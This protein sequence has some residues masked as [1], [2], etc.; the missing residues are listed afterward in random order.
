MKHL[1]I[2]EETTN[3]D[4]ELANKTIVKAHVVVDK[5]EKKNSG[6]HN[7]N[8]FLKPKNSKGYN[9][10]S[11]NSKAKNKEC[12]NC[13]KIGHF[14]KDCHQLKH[15][16]DKKKD[17][18]MNLELVWFKEL[19]KTD[20][21]S[22][23]II[24]RDSP[25]S[26]FYNHSATQA[27]LAEAALLRST[28][29]INHFRQ[30]STYGTKIQSVV[31]GGD[32]EYLMKLSVGS[33]PAEGFAILDTGS[34]LVWVQCEECIKC[35]PQNGT[36]F[37][38]AKSSTYKNVSCYSE[39]C[40]ALSPGECGRKREN[41]CEYEYGYE[42]GTNTVGILA[43]D[44]CTFDSSDGQVATFPDSVFGCGLKQGGEWESSSS[45]L[46]GL[47][48]GPLSRVSQLGAQIEHKFSYCLLPSSV[49]ST[50]NFRFGKDA[51]ITGEGVV[52][53]PIL[54]KLDPS[55][56]FLNLEGVTIGDKRFAN[57]Q[58]GPGEGKII[59][60]SGTT[61]N[62]F[63]SKLHYNLKA[64]VKKH[65]GLKPVPHPPTDFRLCYNTIAFSEVPEMTTVFH[66]TGAD[67][68]LKNINIFM[69]IDNITCLGMLHAGDDVAIYGV[70]A[71]MNF[72][73]AYDLQRKLVS[74]APA[75]GTKS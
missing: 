72:Q 20:G 16:S 66:F 63:H 9:P 47:G 59:I 61:F 57:K 62:Y 5:D 55:F 22:V 49:N 27:E 2:E 71:Q 19:Y 8:K 64:A 70:F 32:G 65:M 41:E 43:T 45:G 52:S 42:D 60:D 37:D 23:D 46:L 35:H 40:Q 29:R 26:P 18:L 50:S 58:A 10:S 75:D 67:V 68:T 11:S 25:L 51:V 74:F 17:S 54:S 48:S 53:T 13:H 1:H 34:D 30:S 39:L 36:R 3:H 38:P 12:Y 15:G 4:K 7:L 28:A 69:E 73:V 21:F 33:P 56:Y 6:R 14:A 44:T 24:H 31:I